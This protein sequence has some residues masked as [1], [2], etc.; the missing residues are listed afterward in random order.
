[1]PFSLVTEIHKKMQEIH[2][3]NHQFSK[4]L[5]AFVDLGF[6][7]MELCEFY[8]SWKNDLLETVKF[9]PKSAITTN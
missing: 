4:R 1:M 5:R 3:D 6:P 2:K 7:F 8:P 9:P